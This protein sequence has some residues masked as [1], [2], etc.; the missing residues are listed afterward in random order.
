MSVSRAD[1]NVNTQYNPGRISHSLLPQ[2]DF[3]NIDRL[4][5]MLVITRP[6]N[7]LLLQKWIEIPLH[8][9]RKAKREKREIIWLL[10]T[11]FLKQYLQHSSSDAK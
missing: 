7:L 8:S 4:G 2:R 1:N 6:G 9:V 3:M 11:P 10:F 5:C